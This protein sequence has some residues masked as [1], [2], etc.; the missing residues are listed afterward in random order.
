MMYKLLVV[1]QKFFFYHSCV[2]LP[3]GGWLAPPPRRFMCGRFELRPIGSPDGVLDSL[4]SR[5]SLMKAFWSRL[6]IG[7]WRWKRLCQHW[8]CR[9]DSHNHW[10]ENT[11]NINTTEI[12]LSF[13][14]WCVLPRLNLTIL[15]QL[16][17]RKKNN[18]TKSWCPLKYILPLN[19]QN[20]A[21]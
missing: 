1:W 14:T 4:Y 10:S 12:L 15:L 9:K 20:F 8:I 13:C 19:I 6:V 11:S 16:S 3:V 18:W 2:I 7:K 21:D 17:Q 5:M